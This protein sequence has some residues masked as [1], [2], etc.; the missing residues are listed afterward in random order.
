[1][2]GP[3]SSKVKVT[4][5]YSKRFRMVED[6]M[7]KRYNGPSAERLDRPTVIEEMIDMTESTLQRLRNLECA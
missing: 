2:L 3:R 6:G 4:E 7:W 1:M 5:K